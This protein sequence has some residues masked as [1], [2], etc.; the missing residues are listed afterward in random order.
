MADLK[1]PASRDSAQQPHCLL[2][3][4]AVPNA[5]KSALVGWLGD[6]LKVRLKSPPVDGKANAELCRF[7]AEI[8]H[9]P[10]GA[11]TLATGAAAR[12]KRVRIAGI[13]LEQVGEK[14]AA[15]L[16]A[17]GQPAPP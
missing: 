10:R 15:L 11:V 14:I 17:N 13:S 4:K 2:T 9:L 12:E 6:A 7:L 1:K 3:I 8:L 5:P 16:I